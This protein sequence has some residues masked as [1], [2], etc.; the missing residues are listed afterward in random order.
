MHGAC[1][2]VPKLDPDM[3]PSPGVIKAIALWLINYFIPVQFDIERPALKVGTQCYRLPQIAK[4]SG[5]A[6]KLGL[7]Q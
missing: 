3:L 2:P 7:R 1:E 6:P 4:E 5:K